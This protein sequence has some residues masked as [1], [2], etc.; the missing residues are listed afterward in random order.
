MQSQA[1]ELSIAVDDVEKCLSSGMLF[2]F[3]FTG[4]A[5]L[6]AIRFIKEMRKVS[7]ESENRNSDISGIS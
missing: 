5:G 1:E 7:E 3:K 4:S 6:E 2:G